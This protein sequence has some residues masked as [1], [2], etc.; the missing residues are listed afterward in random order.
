MIGNLIPLDKGLNERAAAKDF[1]Q[2]LL[3]FKESELKIVDEFIKK[4]AGQ[5]KWTDDLIEERSNELAEFCYT[6]I[7]NLQDF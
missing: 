2:K 5:T 3:I 6:N 7:W 4:Y 1:N